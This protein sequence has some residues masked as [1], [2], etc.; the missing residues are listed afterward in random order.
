MF[1]V[2]VNSLNFIFIGSKLPTYAFSALELARISSGMEINLIANRQISSKVKSLNIR[3]TNLEDFYDPAEFDELKNKSIYPNDFRGGFWQ[4]T[5]ERFFV[6]DQYL[7]HS[8]NDQFFHAELDQLLFR[9]DTLVRAIEKTEFK[10]VFFPFHKLTHACASIY[11][12]NDPKAARDFVEFTLKTKVL[13]SDMQLLAEWS[14]EQSQKVFVLPTIASERRSTEFSHKLKSECIRAAELD[15][16]VDAA[17]LGQWIGGEDPR[18]IPISRKPTNRHSEIGISELLSAEEMGELRFKLSQN[19]T[20]KVQYSDGTE[21]SIYNLHLHSKI[22]HWL[23][24]SRTNLPKLIQ[25]SNQSKLVTIPTT[26]KLQVI[27][28]LNTAFESFRRNPVGVVR[29]RLRN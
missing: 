7:R 9:T 26:R 2:N 18:N 8:G 21:T 3:F 10:G 4:K 5:L 15:G 1:R 13:T 16:I 11:Y 20:L 28:F 12:C 23:L 19:A 25:I 14:Q 17:Q 29:L 27:D 24:K 22:H 6:I